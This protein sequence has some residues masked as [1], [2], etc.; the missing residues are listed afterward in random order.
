MIIK[1]R[2][3]FVIIPTLCCASLKFNKGS[4]VNMETKVKNND[5]KHSEQHKEKRERKGE[6]NG[7]PK[8]ISLNMYEMKGLCQ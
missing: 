8:Y 6:T 5:K 4:V 2:G 3:A 7:F 1:G